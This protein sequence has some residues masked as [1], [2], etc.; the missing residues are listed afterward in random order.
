MMK[1]IMLI[2]DDTDHKS[3]DSSNVLTTG[4]LGHA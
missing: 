1:I 3:N 2:N 4:S